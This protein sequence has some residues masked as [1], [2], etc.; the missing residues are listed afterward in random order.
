MNHTRIEEIKQVYLRI[1]GTLL[2]P[3]GKDFIKEINYTI[4]TI[5]TILKKLYY[6]NRAPDQYSN[7]HFKFK[8]RIFIIMF[9]TVL[10]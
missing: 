6:L 10:F 4:S 8:N 3:H 1:L 2:K 9:V 5:A 7:R